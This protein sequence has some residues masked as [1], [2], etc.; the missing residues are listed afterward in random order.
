MNLSVDN[1]RVRKTKKKKKNWIRKS[2]FFF[3]GLLLLEIHFKVS[4]NTFLENDL[5]KQDNYAKVR[6]IPVT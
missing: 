5:F 4:A 6:L 1:L 3:R 2:H